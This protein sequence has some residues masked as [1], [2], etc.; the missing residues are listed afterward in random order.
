MQKIILFYLSFLSKIL[1]KIKKPYIIGVTASAGKTTI[2][3][4]VITY[5][6]EEFGAENVEFSRYNYNG[7]YGLPLTIIGAKT[8]GK[9]PLLWAK[10]FF[11]FLKKIFQK[12]PHFLVLEYG[13]D[14]IGEMDFLI[15]IARPDIAIIGEVVPNHM[16]QFGTEEAYRKE[17]LKLTA[18]KNLII[19]E[20]LRDFLDENILKKSVF[21]GKNENISNIFAKKISANTDGTAGEIIFENTTHHINVPMIGDYQIINA[22][23]IFQIAKI[24]EKNPKNIEKISKKFLITSGRSGLFEA[25]NHSKIIDGSYNGGFLSLVEGMK[26]TLVFAEKYQIFVFIGDMR[27]LGDFEQEKHEELAREA[28]KIFENHKNTEF[29]LVGKVM[30]KYAKPILEK[31]FTTFSGLSSRKM[32][33][34][35]AEKIET[36]EKKILVF[37]K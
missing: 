30:Q 17:K 26:S 16:E 32:G 36:S 25:K 12:Y 2:S 1:L 9:N 6:E 20:S 18:G 28:I 34:I 10:V 27:E 3:K 15:S 8:G 29:F 22:L 35:I 31:N 19:H 21:Y 7:E 4:F 13:I 33:E 5:L 14:H 37:V 24:L 23:P 11:V